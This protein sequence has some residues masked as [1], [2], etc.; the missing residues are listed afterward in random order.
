M[1]N[2]TL[3]C[4]H[5]YIILNLNLHINILIC[6]HIHTYTGW[7][8]FE[9]T[10]ATHNYPYYINTTADIKGFIHELLTLQ[11]SSLHFIEHVYAQAG[12]LYTIWLT[13]ISNV[14]NSLDIDAYIYII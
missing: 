8:T 9:Y 14:Y 3:M 1:L 4:L 10:L 13:D 2:H 6:T 7:R 12:R 11:P 5:M